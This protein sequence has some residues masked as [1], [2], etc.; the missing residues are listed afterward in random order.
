M[1]SIETFRKEILFSP[2]KDTYDSKISFNPESSP[3]LESFDS[4]QFFEISPPPKKNLFITKKNKTSFITIKKPEPVT[5]K[6]TKIKRF[7]FKR[8]MDQTRKNQIRLRFVA[9]WN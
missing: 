2:E 7:L 3:V 9:I 5:Q 8:Q 1:E 4:T 6:K